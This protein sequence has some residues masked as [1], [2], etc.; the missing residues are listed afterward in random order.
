MR[1]FVRN[2]GR[3]LAGPELGCLFDMAHD[4]TAARLD[5][6]LLD[7]GERKGSRYLARCVNACGKFPRC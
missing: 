4:Q 5:E 6:A 2:F 7:A 1:Q 3:T